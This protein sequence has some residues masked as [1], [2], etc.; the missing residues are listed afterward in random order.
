MLIP[1]RRVWLRVSVGLGLLL[2]VL[3]IL[4][5]VCSYLIPVAAPGWMTIVFVLLAAGGG[6]AVVLLVT[7]WECRRAMDTLTDHVLAIRKDPS[8]QNVQALGP[9][10][11]PLSYQ[12][13]TLG[14]CYRQALAEVVKQTDALEA[15]R[16]EQQQIE[17]AVHSLAGR[18]DAEEGRSFFRLRPSNSDSTTMAA[19][20]TPSLHWM[21]ATPAL[22]KLLGFTLRELN[23]RPFLE[24]VHPD[25]APAVQRAFQEALETGE[26]HNITFRL[27]A[28]GGQEMVVQTDVLTRY[29]QA[30][31]PLHLRCHFL[32]ITE[33]VRKDQELRRLATELQQTNA[34][35]RRTNRELDDFTYVVSHD[36]KEPLRT[37][38]AFS[39]FLAQDYGS[40]LGTE[41]QEYIGHLIEASRRLGA[42]IDDL[43]T[44]SR[45]GRI[46]NSPQ[47]FDLQA[48]V[49]LVRGDL[50]DLIHRRQATLRVEGILPHVAGDPL[51]IVQLLTNLVSNGLKYNQQTHPE[52]VIA[53]V[54]PAAASLPESS[55][56]EADH[57]VTICVRDNG[58]G[59]DPK[60]HEQIFGIFRR[61]HRREE[62][63]GTGAGLAIC[64]KI[65][66]A[67]GG[68][69]WLDSQPGQGTVFYFTLP[70]ALPLP[71]ATRS[72][73][74]SLPTVAAVPAVPPA[75]L[76]L[77]GA[78]ESLAP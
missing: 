10:W 31:V 74:S 37:L 9:E 7:R 42:L 64:K 8:V 2:A 52:V 39:T 11:L 45:A 48:S 69:I 27:H 78:A 32:N 46:L 34:Q 13:E 75:P 16:A 5:A 62:F 19:R 72:E 22:Q 38:Q 59:I 29:R 21:A 14:Q 50:A 55:P 73:V 77:A 65:V 53:A 44:L 51:R 68:R 70:C 71:R 63:E 24:R 3:A 67:H 26:G 25:D 30:N 58:I 17:A 23:S 54:G 6:A 33:R 56:G 15:L 20:L 57:Q 1:N 47:V 12:V 41:G 18:A 49:E 35:L 76:A 36:L 43:L 4:V 40:L 60:Y 61:L 28:Q 66:E